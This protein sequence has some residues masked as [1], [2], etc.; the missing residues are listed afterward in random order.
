MQFSLVNSS[1]FLSLV[2]CGSKAP[3]GYGSAVMEN[4]IAVL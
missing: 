2:V 1:R 3:P 4:N